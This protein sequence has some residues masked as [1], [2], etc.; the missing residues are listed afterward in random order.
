MA[1][2]TIKQRSSFPF[3][4]IPKQKRQINLYIPHKIIINNQ[5]IGIMQ[6]PCIHIQL[7]PGHYEIRIQSM[8][9]YFYSTQQ[10]TVNEGVANVMTFGDNERWWDILFLID[11]VA[12][13]VVSIT[14]LP[15][16]WNLIY[17]V[18]SNG[19]FIAWIIYEWTIRK[20]YFATEF[21][22]EVLQSE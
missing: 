5:L 11:I 15:H 4:N 1:L 14:S 20:H 19:Y 10:I 17:K 13:I 9:P 12:S 7:P 3:I 2:L 8:F 16:P 21:H 22:A 18:M 6:Q